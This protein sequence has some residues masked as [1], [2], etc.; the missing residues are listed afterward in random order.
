RQ[1]LP[2]LGIL[3]DSRDFLGNTQ[4][5]SASFGNL[6]I[7]R[8]RGLHGSRARSGRLLGD[9]SNADGRVLPRSGTAGCSHSCK[10]ILLLWLSYG[11]RCLAAAAFNIATADVFRNGV[12][13]ATTWTG[14]FRHGEEPLGR[15]SGPKT[16]P[17]QGRRCRSLLW[18]SSS[19]TPRKNIS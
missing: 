14:N 9:R 17:Q 3:D 5:R 19:A 10:R 8:F 13:S 12:S 18:Y 4:P 16:S 1:P 7:V 15:F 6:D 11:E 2:P